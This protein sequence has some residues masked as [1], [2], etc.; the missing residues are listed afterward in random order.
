[1]LRLACL[2]AMLFMM[3]GCCEVFGIC[4]S[5]NVHTRASSPEKLVRLDS[6]SFNQLSPWWQGASASA[7][8]IRLPVR[9]IN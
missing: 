1:M 2:I 8:P 9:S 4:T 3:S 5:V 6:R 7:V